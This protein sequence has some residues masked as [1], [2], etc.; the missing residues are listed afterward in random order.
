MTAFGCEKIC[1]Q[2]T[3]KH[4]LFQDKLYSLKAHAHYFTALI[5]LA[6]LRAVKLGIFTHFKFTNLSRCRQSI[7][8]LICL[9]SIQI[10]SCFLWVLDHSRDCTSSYYRHPPPPQKKNIYIWLYIP[11]LSGTGPTP[12][13]FDVYIN[14]N[15]YKIVF[16]I[17]K[18]LRK[19]FF[20]MVKTSVLRKFTS[21][22]F[23]TIIGLL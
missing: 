18:Y 21:K 11:Y 14:I 2:I 7:N 17:T 4:F 19:I 8:S 15:T 9:Y 1:T 16:Q 3:K 13:Q 6:T 10:S 5:H 23:R 22:T 12:C 20:L